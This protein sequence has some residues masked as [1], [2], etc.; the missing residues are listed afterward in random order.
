MKKRNKEIKYFDDVAVLN[1]VQLWELID[2]KEFAWH[3]H[4]NKIPLHLLEDQKVLEKLSDPSIIIYSPDLLEK[5]SNKCKSDDKNKDIFTKLITNKHASFAM[6]EMSVKRRGDLDFVLNILQ[7]YKERNESSGNIYNDLTPRLKNLKKVALLAIKTGSCPS[8]LPD[9]FKG[10]ID[11]FKA[12]IKY[13]NQRAKKYKREI[14]Y[15]DLNEFKFIKMDLNLDFIA[16]VLQKDPHQYQHICRHHSN[17]KQFAWVALK[18]DVCL[19][20]YLSARIKKN[21]AIINYVGARDPRLLVKNLTPQTLMKINYSKLDLGKKARKYIYD[22]CKKTLCKNN[23][24]LLEIAACKAKIFNF[25]QADSNIELF[26]NWH[27]SKAQVLKAISKIPMNKSYYYFNHYDCRKL[28]S[29]ISFD[30]KYDF[31]ILCQ[32]A[33]R[34]GFATA[35]SE[36]RLLELSPK[37]IRQINK[38]LFVRGRFNI[39]SLPSNGKLRDYMVSRIC[40]FHC[41]FPDES[42]YDMC[43]IFQSLTLNEKVKKAKKYP[44]ILKYCYPDELISIKKFL[45]KSE[46][47]NLINN[48]EWL[49]NYPK[50]HLHELIGK[51]YKKNLKLGINLIMN[52]PCKDSIKIIDINYFLKKESFLAFLKNV[53]KITIHEGDFETLPVSLRNYKLFVKKA[54][55]SELNLFRKIGKSLQTDTEITDWVFAVRP[56]LAKFL[57][58]GQFKKLDTTNLHPFSRKI[59]YKKYLAKY[60]ANDVL[61][62]ALMKQKLLQINLS[63]DQ[64]A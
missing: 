54:L 28:L 56:D 63:E 6:G 25:P 62:N 14:N 15:H 39:I 44:H 3:K 46:L 57:S 30:L 33:I 4:L 26:N 41:T 24:D 19:Y 8:D 20:E 5:L 45:A 21:T 52:W 51:S 59:I 38:Y 29:N 34:G 49:S 48:K 27:F 43:K 10:D 9:K 13:Q 16:K 31:D 1:E 35:D 36:Y 22:I 32:L 37:L 18:Y 7:I 47:E 61:E 17:F 53:K 2:K 12:Y 64:A 23:A 50:H 40:A 42:Y 55:K 11:I 60:A 58:E